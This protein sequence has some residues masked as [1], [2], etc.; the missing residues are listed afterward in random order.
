MEESS[1]S[2]LS[3]RLCDHVSHPVSSTKSAETPPAYWSL[4]TLVEV[5]HRTSLGDGMHDLHYS[6]SN[7]YA[8]R[9]FV[10]GVLMEESDEI[11]Q[12]YAHGTGDA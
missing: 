8:E 10:S 7:V 2:V 11:R 4:W 1:W 3:S 12:V 6:F 9:R 5:R